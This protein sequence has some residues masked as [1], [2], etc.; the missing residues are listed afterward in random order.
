VVALNAY[1]AAGGGGYTMWR[2]AERISEGGN[3]RDLLIADAR[4]RRHLDLKPSGNWRLVN[5]P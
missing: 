4:A 2:G 1:R 5:A 3:L